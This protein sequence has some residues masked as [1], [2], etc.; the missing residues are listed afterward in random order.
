MAVTL[1][2]LSILFK[3]LLAS[4]DQGQEFSMESLSNSI[5]NFVFDPENNLTFNSWIQRHEDIFLKDGHSLDSAARCRL[6]LRKLDPLCYE[7]YA[8]YILP[9][10]PRD[11]SFD[12]TV[13]ILKSLFGSVESLTKIRFSCL[14]AEK[15]DSE[16]FVT[17][18]S[19]VNKLCEDFQFTKMSIDD[20]KCII[21][22]FGLKS[23][24]YNDIRTRLLL[25]LNSQTDIKME[26]IMKEIESIQTIKSDTILLEQSRP[27]IQAVQTNPGASGTTHFKQGSSKAPKTPC[28]G[29]GDMHFFKECPF[30]N[31]CCVL[32]KKSGHKD[33]FCKFSSCTKNNL[34]NNSNASN[35]K[36]TFNK[37]LKP[38]NSMVFAEVNSI[39]YAKERKFVQIVIKNIENHT[40][41]KSSKIKMQ[42]DTGSDIT[43]ISKTNWLKLGS[44]TMS[45][46]SEDEISAKS[47]SEHGLPIISKFECD[48]SLIG[49]VRRL[50]IYVTELSN[51][52]LLGI[53]LF[54]AF[55]LWDQPLNSIVC[56]TVQTVTSQDRIS[57]LK[58]SYSELFDVKSMG[59]CTK[60]NVKLHL[61]TNAKPVFRPSRPIAYSAQNSVEAE[62]QR[63]ESLGVITPIEYSEWAAPIVVVKKP[64]G[65]IRICGDY[66]TGL[67]DSL[68]PHKYP[69]PVPNDILA[70]LASSKVFTNIDLSDAYFQVSVDDDARKL[71]T[72]NTHKGLYTF[73][74]LAMGVKVAPGIFQQLMDTMFAD[75]SGVQVYMD[76][77]VVYGTDEADH[78]I[79]LDRVLDRL[80][81][82]GFKIRFEKCNF[83]ASHI[84]YL[85]H[86]IDANGIQPDPSKI[87]VIKTLPRPTN[88]SQL[89]S[90]L[91]AVNYYGKFVPQ[92][93]KHRVHLD[94]LLQKNQ[95]FQWSKECEE[96]FENF[97][98]ILQSKLL[99][100][101]YD[102]SLP[103]KVA[104]DASNLGIGATLLHVYPNGSE[105]A[106]IHASRSLTAPEKNY[107]QIEKEGLALIFAV[108]KF[109]RYIFGR[110]FILET[111]H[112]PLLSIFGSKKG[113]PIYTAN[114]LQRWALT[115]MSY[116][117]TIKYVKTTEFGSADV[118]SRLIE[119]NRQP[120]EEFVIAS[121]QTENDIRDDISATLSKLPITYNMVVSATKNDK[122]LKQIKE[123]I[124]NGWPDAAKTNESKEFF[125]RRDSLSISNDCIMF[126]DRLVIPKVYQRRILHQLHR[127]H[128]GVQRM[129]SVARSYV[130]WPNIDNHITDFVRSCGKCASVAKS[131]VKTTLSS[132]PLTTKPMERIH[133]DIAGPCF[134]SFFVVI[135]D[136]FS[137]WP[138][139]IQTPSTTSSKMIEILAAM[140]SRYGDP[141]L[142]VT[143]NGSQFVS[144]QFEDFLKKRGILHLTS[145]P[146]HPQSNGQAERFVDTL[147]RAIKKMEGEGTS[148]ECLQTFLQTFRSTRNPNSPN[149]DSPA[150]VFIGRKLKTSLDLLSRQHPAEQHAVNTK[151]N[152][153]FNNQHH[154]KSRSFSQGDLVFAKI[155]KK[156]KSFW[157]PGEIINSI[158]N[159]LYKVKVRLDD[160]V[161]MVKSHTNQLRKRYSN[162]ESS[163]AS[164]PMDILLSEF[165]IN[166]D[167][168]HIPGPEVNTTPNDE[169][170][171]RPNTPNEVR[172]NE[173]NAA[174]GG[175]TEEDVFLTPEQIPR[176]SRGRKLKK[177]DRLNYT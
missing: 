88:L 60:A 51:L 83:F 1:E 157:A 74:R 125:Q 118:L 67:N 141:E 81:K 112:K 8:N 54:N 27:E 15:L 98:S 44:P 32:C 143:D 166:V 53:D 22:I 3:E 110:E 103:I 87:E 52:N 21:F 115:L 119:T 167:A 99:L 95:P 41:T 104:A 175:I 156:N 132:W 16:S 116:D 72:I 24:K 163:K 10:L 144:D 77:I 172:E 89:R 114:R 73:N 20:F 82:Y 34:S 153:S 9:K 57:Q 12:E 140:F 86:I 59:L 75:L 46:F 47:A 117:F 58:S 133:L 55:N 171:G 154:A 4:K 62:L 170:P 26:D 155:Y 139:I 18:L 158:G 159:V 49:K 91:G 127:G 124:I 151:Q 122:T 123:Y 33:Q 93:C 168:G 19:R 129:K 78:K 23:E 79:K 70:K 149:G 42:L 174:E 94:K 135:V 146:Y 25:K 17:Y 107:S 37:K 130:Y 173:G 97:K 160:T 138:E 84:K 134:G 106:I 136:S 131:P 31:H 100:T 11:N 38:K 48:I 161:K 66:S 150:E 65:R 68:E 85:G 69:L 45:T 29:C 40:N 137:K 147:K 176:S 76:D 71:L 128:P 5:P 169:I 148:E 102:P 113:I 145:S 120:A 64:N 28:W 111:D 162:T 13:K 6:L 90:F 101:H 105:K 109:H 14:Q 61:K 152:A 92:I 165:Q 80:S 56:N 30:K 177:V 50:T 96:S 126:A 121:V 108:K 39:N 164:I 43:I 7:R 2:Q 35:N 142:V 36:K 63:L